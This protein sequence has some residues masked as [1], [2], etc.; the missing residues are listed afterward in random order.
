MG[1][2]SSVV[3]DSRH[4]QPSVE[5]GMP[6]DWVEYRISG[7]ISSGWH[8]AR[9]SASIGTLSDLV[10]AVDLATHLAEREANLRSVE[11]KVVLIECE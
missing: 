7:G 6:M 5:V 4:N 11:T 9:E 2:L 3:H 8:V 10:D 1:L